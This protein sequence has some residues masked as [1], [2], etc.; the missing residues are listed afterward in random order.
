MELY[1]E[2]FATDIFSEDLATVNALLEDIIDL[3]NKC[4]NAESEV[5][6]MVAPYLYGGRDIVALCIKNNDIVRLVTK[7]NISVG[8]VIMA[9]D[10]SEGRTI[11]YVYAG[12]STLVA[13]DSEDNTCKA[14]TMTDSSYEAAHVLVTLFAYDQ[15]VILR[16]SMTE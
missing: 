1:K 9:Y 10:E 4:L 5:Y 6:G 14:I 12:D 16:P 13:I 8:D 11:V 2:V 7:S 15:Y 3:T